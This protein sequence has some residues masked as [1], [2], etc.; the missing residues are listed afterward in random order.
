MW[1]GERDPGFYG[2]G[3]C[4]AGFDRDYSDKKI[5][6]SVIILNEKSGEICSIK[7]YLIRIVFLF[8]IKIAMRTRLDYKII[9]ED[10][11]MKNKTPRPGLEP[12]SKAPQAS[13]MSTTPP[14]RVYCLPY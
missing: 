4:P 6:G 8:W 14:G 12:G 2:I 9:N 3:V 13:R 7:V 10:S 1:E 5:W 11:D